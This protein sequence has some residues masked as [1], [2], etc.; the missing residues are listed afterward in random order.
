M[1]MQDNYFGAAKEVVLS[2]LQ[3]TL[4]FNELALSHLESLAQTAVIGFYPK[5]TLVLE[6]DKTEVSDLY[7]IQKGGV[8]VF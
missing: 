8:R 3:R 5:G 1:S 6:Q 7:L 2:F 4:P